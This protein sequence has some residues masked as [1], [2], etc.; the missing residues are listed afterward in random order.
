MY[1]YYV[2]RQQVCSDAHAELM[3]QLN[4]LNDTDMKALVLIIN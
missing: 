2:L 3:K 1:Y 4:L